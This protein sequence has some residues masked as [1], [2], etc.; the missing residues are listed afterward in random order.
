MHSCIYACR[1]QMQDEINAALCPQKNKKKKTIGFLCADCYFCIT[2]LGLV[3]SIEPINPATF[4]CR[5]SIGCTFLCRQSI[6][7]D[8][9]NFIYVAH[10][11]KQQ[12][13]I[14]KNVKT[15]P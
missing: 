9:V 12:N 10:Y 14:V 15:L 2:T 11:R 13:D 7:C 3:W 8:V 1:L 6:G 4:L 5:Q